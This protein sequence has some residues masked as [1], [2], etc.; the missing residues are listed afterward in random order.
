MISLLQKT[1]IIESS[2][3]EEDS[4]YFLENIQKDQSWYLYSSRDY[5]IDQITS[6][7]ESFITLQATVKLKNELFNN[8]W[9]PKPIGAFR[10]KMTNDNSWAEISKLDPNLGFLVQG[11][12]WSNGFYYLVSN[13]DFLLEANLFVDLFTKEQYNYQ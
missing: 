11:A 6:A 4:H 1:S 9:T 12:Y 7:I 5:S 8:F 2:Y 13:D 10:Y 3:D